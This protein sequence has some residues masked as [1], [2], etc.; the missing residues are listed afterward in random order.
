[1]S[2]QGQIVAVQGH[3]RNGQKEHGDES[4][5]QSGQP[6]DA[7]KQQKTALQQI[8]YANKLNLSFTSIYR[9]EY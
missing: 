2:T 1:M 8:I 4:Q 6:N 3:R 5:V 9:W 7:L